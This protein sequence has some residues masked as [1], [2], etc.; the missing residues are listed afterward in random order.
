M[1]TLFVP[2]T[3]LEVRQLIGDWLAQSDL[4]AEW[5]G[6]IERLA[7]DDSMEPF[8]RELP[9]RLRDRAVD[10]IRWATMAYSVATSQRPP[11]AQR[12]RAARND[13]KVLENLYPLTYP[14]IAVAARIL[15]QY[16]DRVSPAEWAEEWP[17]DTDLTLEK[18]RLIIDDI[19]ACSDRLEKKSQRVLATL[20]LPRP[21]RKLGGRTAQRV[22]FSRILKKWFQA[23]TGR[24]CAREVA[25]LE[26]VL[27]N[28]PDAVDESTT[29]K[30]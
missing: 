4:D 10:V 14:M 25:T 20:D 19:A 17:G 9:A 13:P 1:A 12:L 23:E 30:R 7:R 16:L 26:Q 5:R 27:F 3:P 24:V 15:R 8:W 28:L 6:A 11:L 18:Q 22:Y 2:G 21:P 29:R